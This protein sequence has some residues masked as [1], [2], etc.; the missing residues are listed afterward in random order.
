MHVYKGSTKNGRGAT[1]RSEAEQ[2]SRFSFSAQKNGW[3]GVGAPEG[4]AGEP[5]G[6]GGGQPAQARPCPQNPR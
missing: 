6:G 5:E 1:G 3:G 2:T 4:V